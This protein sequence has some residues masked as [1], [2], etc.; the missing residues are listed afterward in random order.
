[1]PQVLGSRRPGGPGFEADA[2]GCRRV[3][4]VAAAGV[5]GER[6]AADAARGNRPQEEGPAPDESDARLVGHEPY[7]DRPHAGSEELAADPALLD[8]R[9]STVAGRGADRLRSGARMRGA[10][11]AV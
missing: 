9:S 10:H 5:G 4:A 6:G 1:L 11:A 8:A 3:A 7:R 2:G